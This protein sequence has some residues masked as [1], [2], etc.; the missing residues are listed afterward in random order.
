VSEQIELPLDDLP[1]WKI[2]NRDG[3]MPW[4]R[5]EVEKMFRMVAKKKT[6]QQIADALGRSRYS[7]IAKLYNL[8]KLGVN[9]TRNSS[10]FTMEVIEATPSIKEARPRLKC[11][12]CRKEFESRDVKKNRVCQD[13]KE[14][15][16]WR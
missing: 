10:E 6:N 8:S 7:V 5:E 1:Q 16:T 9:Y 4:T 3:T 11:L 2:V 14:S 12:C 15:E 13:C